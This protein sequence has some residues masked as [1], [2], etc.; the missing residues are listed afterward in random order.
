MES[1][2]FLRSLV[3]AVLCLTSVNLAHSQE[4]GEF[5]LNATPG[6][7][8]GSDAGS[9]SKYIGENEMISWEVYVPENYD[10][11]RPAGVMVFAG[12]PRNVRAPSGWLSVMKDKNL[13]WVAARHSGNGAS[14]FQKELL[15]MMSVPLI[16][17]DY[18]IDKSRIYITGEGR[19]AGRAVMNY[20]QLFKGAIFMGKQIW[21]NN[22][23]E[24]VSAIKDNR[25]VFVT[26]ETSAIPKGNRYAYNK[27]KNAGVA[28]IE[29]VIIKGTHRFNRPKFSK[30][31]DYLDGQ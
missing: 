7:V 11:F 2:M 22:A 24:K 21:E 13:I 6:E 14:I 26:R 12:A 23:E 1:D 25:F 9:Y 15:S 8:L 16:E 28:N 17:K 31:I 27:F 10:P 4:T 3:I 29:M 5:V 30:S 20:P 18:A 19:T